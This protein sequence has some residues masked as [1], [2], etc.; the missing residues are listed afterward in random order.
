MRIVYLTIDQ[1]NYS[2]ASELATAWGAELFDEP[3][4]CGDALEQ[5][6]AAIVDLDCFLAA[7]RAEILAHLLA[8][9]ALHPIAVHSYNLDD[10]TVASLRASDVGVFPHMDAAVL[11]FV[12]EAAWLGLADS[13]TREQPNGAP[14]RS[15]QIFTDRK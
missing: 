15:T 4:N 14:V 1:V 12:C 8:G 3:R 6:D 10:R 2:V 7:Q 13:R 9:R 5:Y 11:R